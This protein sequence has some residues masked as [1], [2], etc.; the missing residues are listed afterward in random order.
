MKTLAF[1]DIDGKLLRT[2]Y[3]MQKVLYWAGLALDRVSLGHFTF[4][5]LLVLRVY[6]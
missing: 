1:C 6:L 2:V 4:D 3:G 5:R